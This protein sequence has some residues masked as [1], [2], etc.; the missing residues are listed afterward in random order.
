MPISSVFG[1]VSSLL[2]MLLLKTPEGGGMWVA[3]LLWVARFMTFGLLLRTYII[4]WTLARMSRHVRIRS[5]SLRSIRG[6]YL[7]RGRQTIRI[8]RISYV[9]YGFEI[10]ITIKVEGLNVE[11]YQHDRT[12]APRQS[13]RRSATVE[14]I[15][16]VRRQFWNVLS[17]L[18]ALLDPVVR[19]VIRA[20]VM[21]CLGVFIRWLPSITQQI[22]LEFQPATVIFPNAG[23]AKI[24]AETVY[25]HTNLKIANIKRDKHEK[26][27][28]TATR[29]R[30]ARLTKPL[31]ASYSVSAWKHRLGNSFRRSWNRVVEQTQGHAILSVHLTNITGSIP[32]RTSSTDVTDGEFLSFPGLVDFSTTLS[33]DPQSWTIVNHSSNTTLNVRQCVIE[34]DRLRSL[35]E[36]IQAKKEFNTS[37]C[38]SSYLIS[39][40]SQ[41]VSPLSSAA[42]TSDSAPSVFSETPTSPFMRAF[43]KASMLRRRYLYPPCMRLKETKNPALVAFLSS[44]TANISGL[45]VNSRN[46]SENESYKMSFQGISFSVA[47]SNPLSNRLHRQWLGK[48]V[49]GEVFDPDVYSLS[50]HVE[51]VKLDRYTTRHYLRILVGDSIDV[52]AL[53]SQFPSPWLV[54]TPFI[55]GDPNGPFLVISLNI[56]GIQVTERADVLSTLF[57]AW[58]PPPRPFKSTSTL[59]ATAGMPRFTFEASCGIISAR[60]L[61]QNEDTRTSKAVEMR[62]DGFSVV[63]ASVYSPIP[64]TS[65]PQEDFDTFP[66][67]MA[68]SFNLTLQPVF[69]RIRPRHSQNSHVRLPSLTTSDEDFCEDPVFLSVES[70]DLSGGGKLLG[71]I[72]DDTKN[73]ATINKSTLTLDLSGF[74]EAVV[75]E[76]WHLSVQDAISHLITYVPKR[77]KR[78]ADL[79]RSPLQRLP[80]GINVS[81]F[82]GRSVLFITSPDINPDDTMELSRGIACRAERTMLQLRCTQRNKAYR[83]RDAAM[84]EK[85]NK[86]YLSEKTIAE[87]LLDP[88][89][90]N[91]LEDGISGFICFQ[92]GDL[93]LRDALATQ[94]VAD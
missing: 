57:S 85:R 3:M 36:L 35:F 74:T 60:L 2:S 70:F 29:D 34:L 15:S 69:I 82:L 11:V 54:P 25:V 53:V 56:G 30:M 39:P 44:F 1:P 63:C 81:L 90:S 65:V 32:V 78:D 19:P 18:Y 23:D 42:S 86:L 40:E 77:A 79:S 4:P 93:S 17:V 14:T 16:H 73:I 41:P 59:P 10:G 55:G 80:P 13:H 45:T 20:C 49:K 46:R 26:E 61:Y 92:I 72:N 94:Y 37:P 5:V 58:T 22:T 47:L 50:F 33:F 67:S 62:T 24:S 87:T 21:S 9:W 12:P 91:E 38:S 89:S 83:P 51:S 28:S 43:S 66:L 68:F 48:S 31:R 52:R 71:A 75:V 88:E 6:L 84:T 8:E 64:M 27:L 76:L 7:R